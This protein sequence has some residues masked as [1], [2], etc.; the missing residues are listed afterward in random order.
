MIK[1]MEIRNKILLPISFLFIV[2]FSLTAGFIFF[3]AR[4]SSIE[5][6]NKLAI[7]TASHYGAKIQSELTGAMTAARTLSSLLEAAAAAPESVN[8][9]ELDR[10]LQKVLLSKE[11]FLGVYV[12][13]EP[14]ALDG[15]DRLFQ[16]RNWHDASGRYYPYFFRQDGKIGI[17]PCDDY[18]TEDYYR[19]AKDSGREVILEPYPEES[20]GGILITSVG[21]PILKDGAVIGVVGIDIALRD[22]QPLV[23]AATPMGTGHGILVSHGGLIVAHPEESYSGKQLSEILEQALAVRVVA[24]MRAGQIHEEVS[25][26]KGQALED[27]IISVPFEVGEAATPWSFVAVVPMKTILAESRALFGLGSGMVVGAIMVLI[28]IVYFI[29]RSVS[30]PIHRI[31]EMVQGLEKGQ[32]NCRLKMNRKDEVGRLALTM[33][34]FA[35]NLRDEVLEAF[36]CLAAGDFTFKAKGLIREPLAKAN[37]AICDLIQQIQLTGKQ[38]AAGSSQIADGSQSLSQGAT[39]SAASLEEISASMTEVG[40]QTKQSAEHANMARQMASQAKAAA[41]KGDQQMR[42]MVSAMDEISEAGKNISKIIK[43]IDEIAFQTNLLALNAAVEAARAGQHGKGFAVVAEEVRNLAARSAQAAKETAVLIEGSVDKTQYGA[44]IAAQ[45][46]SALDEIVQGIVKVTDLV[47]EIAAASS[48]QAQAIGEINTGLGQIDLVTQSNTA[49]AEESAAAAEELSGQAEQLRQML[50][51][52]KLDQ[53]VG[54]DAA[55]EDKGGLQALSSRI[56]KAY[57]S[58]LLLADNRTGIAK[59]RTPSDIIA[60]EDREFGKY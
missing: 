42:E 3:N 51:R 56:G 49:N 12:V 22:C 18:E 2:V 28:A 53:Q 54:R 48:E 27:L 60:S 5:S 33:D 44:Q 57:D 19:L 37:A 17:E 47:N 32:L 21:V 39:E 10:A 46:A 7:E 25:R 13:F 45:T 35:D 14:N 4:R 9:L 20:A 30:N 43:V 36:N 40:S 50:L 55:F 23:R 11:T 29:A 1:N 24:A 58:K 38:I 6:A 15:R 52:F 31:L 26:R 8:R 34:A 16:N 59:E 41:E